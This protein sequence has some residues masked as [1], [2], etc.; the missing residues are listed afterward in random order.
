MT[1][2]WM[3]FYT[4]H[5]KLCALYFGTPFL[6]LLQRYCFASGHSC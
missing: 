5:V 1:F 6:Q 3:Q 2:K 4:G